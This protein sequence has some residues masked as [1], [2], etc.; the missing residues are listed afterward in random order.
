MKKGY[1]LVAASTKLDKYSRTFCLS[2]ILKRGWS[3]LHQ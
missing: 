1:K 2:R 3:G